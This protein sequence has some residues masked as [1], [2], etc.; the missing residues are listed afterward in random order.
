M[1]RFSRYPNAARSARTPGAALSVKRGLV[2][3]L[4]T[5]VLSPLALGIGTVLLVA[6][7]DEDRPALTSGALSPGSVPAAYATLIQQAAAACRQGLP[8]GVLAAQLKQ[9]SGFNP[10]AQ[11]YQWVTDPRTGRRVKRPLAQGIAQFI[12]ATWQTWGRGGNVWDPADAIPAQGRFMCSLLKKAKQHPGWNGSPIEMAL[13]GYNAGWGAVERF[14]GVPPRSFAAGQ[15]YD[16]VRKI[17]AMSRTFTVTA[18]SGHARLPAGFRLP[19]DTPSQVRTA[20]TWAL[21]QRGGL[22][23]LGGTCTDA[24]G[25]NPRRWCDCSSLTQQAYRA[26]GID[27]PRTTYAQVTLPKAVDLDRPKPGD[28]VFNPGSDGSDARPGH[29]AMYVGEGLVIEAPRT[30]L[31]TRLVTYASLRNSTSPITRVSALRRVV[32]W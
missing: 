6:V 26:A 11:S 24:H 22:Y 7:T 15:T 19:A 14:H 30:G 4:A 12:P 32:A 3:L 29:V 10:R 18:A 28:L 17:M 13:A 9:E 5:T 21:R 16:Y 20:V 1:C 2:L 8:A 23:R 25:R 31:R 27:I